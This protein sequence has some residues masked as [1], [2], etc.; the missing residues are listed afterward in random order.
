M[1][2]T[3]GA[4]GVIPW[5]S[6]APRQTTAQRMAAAAPGARTAY[7]TIESYAPASFGGFI[8][9]ALQKALSFQLEQ[10]GCPRSSSPRTARV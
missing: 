3:Y 4:S 6:A 1:P 10:G 8:E 5:G 2:P 9:P 7:D